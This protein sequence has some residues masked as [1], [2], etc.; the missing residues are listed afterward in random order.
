MKVENEKTDNKNSQISNNTDNTT[1]NNTDNQAIINPKIKSKKGLKGAES[2]K[3]WREKM[4]SQSQ[5]QQQIQSNVQSPIVEHRT[6][7]NVKVQKPKHDM[8]IIILGTMGLILALGLSA[9]FLV[10]SFKAFIL[11]KIKL[12]ESVNK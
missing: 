12:K 5:S 4:K 11:S 3:K 2:L 7:K 9:F 10:P 1:I 8:T 6:R